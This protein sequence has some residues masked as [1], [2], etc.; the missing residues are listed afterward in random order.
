MLMPAF[1][2]ADLAAGRLVQP[3]DLMATDNTAYWLVYPE[4]RKNVRKIRAFR[5]WILG[6]LKRQ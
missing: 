3:F 4:T 2:T 1:F 5:D 6:E